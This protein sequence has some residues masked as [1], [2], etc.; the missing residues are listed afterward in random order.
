MWTGK[1]VA[2]VR[3]AVVV[4]R[5]E[6]LVAALAVLADRGSTPRTAPAWA[7]IAGYSSARLPCCTGFTV[8]ASAG[9]SAM[10]STRPS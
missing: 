4:G 7:Y 3:H 9:K 8:C 6:K 1:Y 5:P 10:A 2:R